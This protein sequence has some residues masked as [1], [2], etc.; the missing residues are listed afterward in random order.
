MSSTI[1][2]DNVVNQSGDN[3]SG[4]DLSTNDQVII[5]TA[6][7]TAVTVDSSQ[8]TKIASN[9]D[10]GTIRA[11]NGTSAMTINSNGIVIPKG[12]I[13][14]VKATELNQAYSSS[15]GQVKIQWEAVEIDTISG[16]D[17]S[18]HRYT[19]SVAGY[20]LVGGALR[21]QFNNILSL[22]TMVVRKNN[23]TNAETDLRNQFQSNSD[24]YFNGS[25][26]IPTGL[27]QMNGSTDYIEVFFEGEENATLNDTNSIKSHFFAQL[28]HAT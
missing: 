11:T 23:T 19:P 4:L 21:G 15:S 20:Y 8:N 6:N 28:V 18:N 27:M 17:S 16:W 24:A 22:I 2:V 5:K 10:V 1:K 9:L 14:Q 7:T 13:M 25:Y 3:D 12:V 26:P